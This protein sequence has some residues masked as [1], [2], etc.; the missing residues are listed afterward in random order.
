MMCRCRGHIGTAV[1]PLVNRLG[2]DHFRSYLHGSDCA[3][4]VYQAIYGVYDVACKAPFV[5][6]KRSGGVRIEDNTGF[7]CAEVQTVRTLVLETP[8]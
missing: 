3:N 6:D 5:F 8:C 1:V 7:V 4:F 2:P